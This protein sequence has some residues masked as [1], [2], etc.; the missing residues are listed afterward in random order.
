MR[1]LL[2]LIAL[3]LY[4]YTSNIHAQNEPQEEGLVS[5]DFSAERTIIQAD[6][7][8]LFAK[9]RSFTYTGAVQVDHGDMTLTCKKLD[10]TYTEQNEIDTLV[11]TEDVHIVKGPAIKATGNR[12]VF[13]SEQQTLRLTENPQLE[14]DGS[15]LSADEVIIYLKEDRSEALGNVR[16]TIMEKAGTTEKNGNVPGTP[17]KSKPKDSQ[18]KKKKKK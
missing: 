4:T 10:G 13:Q 2:F 17:T 1:V 18:K 7:M 14:Q 3:V 11:A 15:L 8:L 6:K 12:A 9:K 16:V 5:L